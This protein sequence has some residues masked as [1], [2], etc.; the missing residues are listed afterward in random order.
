[1]HHK[2][3]SQR[4]LYIADGRPFHVLLLITTIFTKMIL[5]LAE[6]LKLKIFLKGIWMETFLWKDCFLDRDG[7]KNS[8]GIIFNRLCHQGL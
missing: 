4:D 8:E 2:L 1:V 6:F 7:V 3:L 5:W